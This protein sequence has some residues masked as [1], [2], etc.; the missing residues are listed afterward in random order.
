MR[1]FNNLYSVEVAADTVVHHLGGLPERRT[2]AAGRTENTTAGTAAAVGRVAC[3][4]SCSAKIVYINMA[5][6]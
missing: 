3:Y 2:V 1:R 4:S 5:S 6:N